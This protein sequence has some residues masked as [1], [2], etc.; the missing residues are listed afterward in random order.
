VK[1]LEKTF[2]EFRLIEIISESEVKEH[3]SYIFPYYGG[4]KYTQ[5]M[6]FSDDMNFML[7][8]LINAR[9]FLY[10]RESAGTREQPNRVRWLPREDLRLS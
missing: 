1:A 10:L 2:Y 5:Y 8:R 9:A 6:F 4:D 7:E 3:L